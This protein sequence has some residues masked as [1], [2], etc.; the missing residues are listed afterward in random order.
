MD[1]KRQR[2]TAPQV[3]NQVRQVIIKR[4]KHDSKRHK[5]AVVDAR[6]GAWIEEFWN[7]VYAVSFIKN[8]GYHHPRKHFFEATKEEVLMNRE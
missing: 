3:K 6:T 5:Y 8:R 4:F 2:K 7:R 1:T